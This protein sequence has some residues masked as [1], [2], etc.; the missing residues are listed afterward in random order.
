MRKIATCDKNVPIF[1]WR[2][3]VAAKLPIITRELSHEGLLKLGN[4]L[5]GRNIVLR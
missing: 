1:G 4:L 2:I 5:S 3:G